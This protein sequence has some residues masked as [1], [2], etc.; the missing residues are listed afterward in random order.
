[1]NILID[2]SFVVGYIHAGQSRM[3]GPDAIDGEWTSCFTPSCA[4]IIGNVCGVLMI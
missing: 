1:M 3:F 4:T 2:R